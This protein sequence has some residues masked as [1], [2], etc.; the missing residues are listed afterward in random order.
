ML[1]IHPPLAK[2]CEPPAGIPLLAGA[3]RKNGLACTVLD[4]N[5]EGIF[6]LLGAQPLLKIG[7]TWSKRAGRNLENNLSSLRS[8]SLYQNPS[9]YNRA[10][11]D[12]NRVLD[13]A[14]RA[15]GLSVNLANYQ[16]PLLSS[17]KSSDLLQAWQNPQDNIFHPYFARRLPQVLEKFCPRAVGFSLNYL[18]Q[19]IT[20]FAMAGFIKR[21]FPGLPVVLG[22]G[23]ITSWLRRPGWRNPFSGMVDH[24]VAGPG[25]GPLLD[26]LGGGIHQG[27]VHY[28]PDYSGLPLAD[29]LA[30]GFILPYAASSGCYWQKCSFCPESAE[31]NP[32]LPVPVEQVVDDI[33]N[34]SEAT[35]PTLIH[36]LDN[37]VSPA[38]L[39]QLIAQP[40]GVKWYGFSRIV[41]E[42]ADVT[43]CQALKESGCVM[44]KLGLESGDQTV[45]NATDKGINITMVSSALRALEKAGIATFVYLLFG[46][47]AESLAEAR[48]TMDFVVS[49]HSAI[50]F[51]NLAVFNMPISSSE[52]HGLT[53][54]T[55]SEGDLSLYTDFE[56]PLGWDRQSIRRFLDEEFKRHPAIDAI[57][58]RIP[59]IFTSNHAPFFC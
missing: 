28:C 9:R 1:L 48:A 24:L 13:M 14:G 7:D 27:N 15:H 11:A 33:T 36:F 37:A 46:T 26:L 49:H 56:H 58:K 25:E 57:L 19:A 18:S 40:P 44:L 51:L 21:H 17:L 22:G 52:V 55:F 47:P 41:P 54:S 8:W 29:Y 16:D 42:L 45:L 35:K 53:T 23:L 50:T 38:L 34:L 59:P 32:Y 31:K 4:A 30:P 10:V 12:V 2:P 20:T 43:F 6:S 3:L 39:R 5:L